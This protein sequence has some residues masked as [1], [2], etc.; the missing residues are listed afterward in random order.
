[1][2][3]FGAVRK[4]AATRGIGRFLANS[5]LALRRRTCQEYCP[6]KIHAI[7]DARP[8]FPLPSRVA[9]GPRKH[10]RRAKPEPLPRAGSL[11]YHVG[12]TQWSAGLRFARG[13]RFLIGTTDH[14]EGR[15]GEDVLIRQ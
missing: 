12:V 8:R 10:P 15:R 9:A 13:G 4:K 6:R 14:R 11:A 5:Y 3:R 2:I 7:P 1:M